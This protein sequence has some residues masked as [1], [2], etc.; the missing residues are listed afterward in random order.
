MKKVYIVHGWGGNP[1]EPMLKW[2]RETLIIR[3]YE[4]I[5]PN[6]PHPDVPTIEDWVSYLD[7]NIKD[8]N[9]DTYL[10][11]HSV[12]CQ[13]ILRYMENLPETTKIGGVILIAPWIKLSVENLG[14]DESP[15]IAKPWMETKI[16]YKKIISHSNNFSAI[17]S[18]N[19][20]FVPL[21]ENENLI[22]ENL[23]AKT[24]VLHNKGHFTEDDGVSSLPEVLE[25]L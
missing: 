9:K 2:L 19:D 20:P 1:D 15:E 23:N 13:T 17:F 12:G 7:L 4:V 6:M 3:G 8:P 16:D 18:D 22:K 24:I 21:S 25:I 11:G 10:A 5:A 14:E